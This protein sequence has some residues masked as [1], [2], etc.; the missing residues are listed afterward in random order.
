MAITTNHIA[1]PQMLEPKIN[2]IVRDDIIP[3]LFHDA[4]MKTAENK[5][6]WLKEKQLLEA[7]LA[8]TPDSIPA[9]ITLIGKCL[10]L[11]GISDNAKEKA[12]FLKEAQNYLQDSFKINYFESKTHEYAYYIQLF[13]GIHFNNLTE[14]AEAAYKLKRSICLSPDNETA[15]NSFKVFQKHVQNRWENEKDCTSLLEKFNSILT[16]NPFQTEWHIPFK[17]FST[18]ATKEFQEKYPY[19]ANQERFSE[20]FS[21]LEFDVVLSDKTAF[22]KKSTALKLEDSNV[23]TIPK[24]INRLGGR[25]LASIEDETFTEISE[26]K[27]II[28]F[29]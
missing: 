27:V 21:P 17:Q 7:S 11:S 26:N 28:K 20:K 24:I 6:T 10:L 12:S 29:Y 23:L 16:C 15:E 14:L 1:R 18:K 4:S 9:R 25:E 8:Q 22:I 19:L 3:S 5:V 13:I 2:P